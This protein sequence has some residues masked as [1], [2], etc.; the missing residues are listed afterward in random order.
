M[1]LKELKQLAEREGLMDLPDFE[2]Q[3]AAWLVTV[4]RAGRLVNFQSTHFIPPDQFDK[5]KPKKAAKFFLL[6]RETARTSGD[7]AFLFYDK[8]EY[9]FGLDPG[10]KQKNDKL[11]S[12]FSLFRERIRACAD[13][14]EDEGARAVL[15]FLDDLAEKRQTMDL[16]DGCAGNDLFVFIYEPDVDLPVVHRPK[17]QAYFEKL[18]REEL[19]DSTETRQCLVT[20]TIGPPVRLFPTVKRVP[21]GSTSGVAL[22]SFNDKAFESHGWSSN[23]NAPM[24]RYAAES[25]STALKRLL[26]PYYPDPDQPDISLP[27]RHLRLS[28]DTAVCFWSRE[29][30]GDDLCNS[31]TGMMEADP[32]SVAAL[33]QCVW[34]GQ[35]PDVGDPSAFYALTLSGTQGRALIRGWFES[36]VAD[37][38]QNIARHYGDLD[39][40]WNTPPPKNGSL[41]PHMP[42]RLLLKS[43]A[44]RGEEKLIP[45]PWIAQMVDA[46]LKG[47]PYP[48]AFFQKAVE[49]YRAE[50]TRT[51]HP[52]DGWNTLRLNDARAALIKA[53]LN[54]RIFEDGQQ[55]VKKTMDPHNRNEGYLLGQLMAVMEKLQTEALGSINAGIVD[56]YFSGASATPRTVFTH[57]LKNAEHHLKKLRDKAGYEGTY[58]RQIGELI[59]RFDPEKGFP[60]SLNQRQQG[61]FIIGYHQTRHWLWLTKEE[62]QTWLLD[63]PDPPRAFRPAEKSSKNN[64]EE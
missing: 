35:A 2:C 29:S 30:S 24:S 33:Y 4:S 55:E 21:G 5:E 8:A 39:M 19:E 45:K 64:E 31:L 40:V 25:S 9:A 7:R 10:A 54:R 37:V 20:G 12:R 18:R 38:A 53:V 34:K 1:I 13:E 16:P 26:H 60:T 63:H 23:E 51:G 44:V 28:D 32:T 58:R 52:K 11:A 17:V 27:K 15:R 62:R 3:Q 48:L 57:L 42:L 43:L 49:R 22:V 36:T 41:P 46:A 47:A 61:L 59:S 14:T 56:K 6:P 50:I